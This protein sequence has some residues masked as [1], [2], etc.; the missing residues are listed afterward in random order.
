MVK[1]FQKVF[2]AQC[3]LKRDVRKRTLAS[4]AKIID[5]I[6]PALDGRGRSRVVKISQ[7]G[8]PH[9]PRDEHTVAIWVCLSTPSGSCTR[10][11]QNTPNPYRSTSLFPE[12]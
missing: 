4:I 1:V 8:L 3:T 6:R 2:W 7:S 12:V 11:S 5:A 9:L 10:C